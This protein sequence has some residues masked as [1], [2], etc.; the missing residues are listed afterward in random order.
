[1]LNESYDGSVI[2]EKK[3]LV[4]G[5]FPYQIFG[6][7]LVV[8]TF[9]FLLKTVLPD[10]QHAMSI[11]E[12]LLSPVVYMNML[13]AL[14]RFFSGVTIY[15]YLAGPMGIDSM[16]SLDLIFLSIALPTAI[17]GIADISGER[18]GKGLGVLIGTIASIVC[19]FVLVGPGALTPSNSRYG[20]YLCIPAVL[21]F[22]VL[23]GSITRVREGQLKLGTLF[24]AAICLGYFHLYYFT[25][26]FHYGGNAELNLRTARVEPKQAAYEAVTQVAPPGKVSIATDEY[27][28]YW[29]LRYLSSNDERVDVVQADKPFL[30]KH[31][32]RDIK[33]ESA[34][35]IGYTGGP[36]D[37]WIKKRR[38]KIK[39]T[40]IYDGAGRP[41]ITVFR[42]H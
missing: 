2:D 17:L 15:T 41:I 11:S 4:E 9:A 18:N 22:S 31:L 13:L 5:N 26:L 33:N 34:F 25:P 6:V 19:F 30:V 35:F 7:L 38:I 23:L 29:P 20:M 14:V 28:L 37:Q 3:S 16:L 10:P 42:F 21:A 24:F 40:Y 32:G 12:R 8:A 27:W 1:M 39:N 36:F